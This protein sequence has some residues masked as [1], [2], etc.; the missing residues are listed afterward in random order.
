MLGRRCRGSPSVPTAA[1]TIDDCEKGMEA[2][3]NNMLDTTSRDCCPQ[4]QIKKIAR[5]SYAA[6]GTVIMGA[7]P[8]KGGG[9]KIGWSSPGSPHPVSW[10]Y[11]LNE[12][13]RKPVISK[14]M[15]KM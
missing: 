1:D 14:M 15:P 4:Q 11:P 13:R 5:R 8:L 6:K 9:S 12:G 7:T 3:T 10:L 2:T